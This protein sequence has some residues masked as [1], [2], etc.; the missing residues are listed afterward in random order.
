MA[1]RQHSLTLLLAVVAGLVGGLISS[2]LLMEQ[3]VFAEKK[4]PHEKVVRAERFELVDED[5]NIFSSLQHEGLATKL[6]IR[7]A[8]VSQDSLLGEIELEATPASAYVT[9]NAAQG[10]KGGFMLS[11]IGENIELFM[12]AL[13]GCIE[14]ASSKG[15]PRLSV[16][17]NAR[18]LRAVLGTTELKHTD[19]G[20]TEIRAPSSLVLFDEKGKVLW[21]AP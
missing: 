19:T 12:G 5:G 10:P 21:S 18:R 1:K 11:S 20:S 16:Q 14:L 2:R 6:T 7:S 3:P 4:A 17:D 9:V 15:G 8:R 13:G